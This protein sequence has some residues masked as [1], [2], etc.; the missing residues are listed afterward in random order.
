MSVETS[1]E[2]VR[3]KHL[4]PFEEVATFFFFVNSNDEK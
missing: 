2:E 3:E 4:Q 1:I